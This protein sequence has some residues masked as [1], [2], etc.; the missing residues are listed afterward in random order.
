[1]KELCTKL[2]CWLTKGWKAIVRVRKVE[3]ALEDLAGIL[4][5]GKQADSPEVQAWLDQHRDSKTLIKLQPVVSVVQTNPE[6]WQII[7]RVLEKE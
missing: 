4:K 6:I 7:V 5:S 3:Q 2:K 1:M